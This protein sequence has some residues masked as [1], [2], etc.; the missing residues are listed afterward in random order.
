MSQSNLSIQATASFS[1]PGARA[2]QEDFSLVLAEKSIFVV[3][4]GFGGPGPG[5]EAARAVCE[6]V[7]RFLHREANDEEATMPFE[8]RS[9]YSLAGNV[10]FNSLIHANRLLLKLNR[11]KGVHERGG[12]SVLAGFMDGDL[13]ALANVGSCTGWLMRA[14]VEAQLATPRTYS[15][16]V[17]P[18]DV[19][20]RED[21][22][23]PLRGA[24]HRR[25][26][27]ARD[28]RGQG[29]ER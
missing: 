8:L 4:D 11:G 26:P 28:L 1:S 13:L 12:A 6:G 23:V 17:D 21:W 19:D 20:P 25:G 3:A 7:K 10:L 24:R 29:A 14:G 15:R 27:R 22:Q 5:A 18:F 16:L 9:Y 2:G